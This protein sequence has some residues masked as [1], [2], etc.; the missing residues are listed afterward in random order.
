MN[1][2]VY[3][4]TKCSTCKKAIAALE[5]AG[6]VLTLVDVRD[7]GVPR[8]VL[9]QLEAAVGYEKLANRASMTWRG[10]SEADKKSFSREKALELIAEHPSLMKRPAIVVGDEV[11]VGWTKAVQAELL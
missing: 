4:L 10:L 11:Y 7:D 9:E 1:L 6:H 2:T 3:H 8:E 5:E